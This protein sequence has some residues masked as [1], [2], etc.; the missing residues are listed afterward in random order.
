MASLNAFKKSIDSRLDPTPKRDR[1]FGFV[2]V[3]LM[4]LVQAAF[5][6][7][8]ESVETPAALLKQAKMET[9]PVK[10]TEILDRALEDGR[11]RGRLRHSL[12]YERG[13]AY[14]EMKDCFRAIDSF[15]SSLGHSWKHIPALIEMAHCLIIVDQ[16]D[17]A[18]RIVERVLKT[19]PESGR[20]YVLRGMI[21]EKQGALSRARD[22]YTRALNYD[23]HSTMALELRSKALLKA[24][25]PR[26]A[27]ADIN[28]LARLARHDPDVFVTRARIHLKLK[29][30]ADA[31]ADY[32]TAAKL[33]RDDDRIVKEKAQVFFKMDQPQ[34][35]LEVLSLFT[36]KRGK[37]AAISVLQ[38]RAH[39]LLKNYSKAERM[40]RHV[41]AGDPSHA[42]ALLYRGVALSRRGKFDQALF[43]LNR[44]IELQPR[45]VEAFKERSRTF[46]ELGDP[47]RAAADLSAAAGLD[48]SDGEI[49]ALRGSTFARRMLYDAAIADF[50]RA[51]QCLPGDPRILYDR[52]AAL[53]HK[54]ELASALKD[55]DQILERSRQ[56]ARALS[57]RGMIQ[58]RQGADSKAGMDF[59]QAVKADPTDPLVW[60]NRG[61]FLYKTGKFKHAMQDLN[62]ALDLDPKYEKA[63]Y[64]LSLVLRRRQAP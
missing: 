55:L 5:P 30:Y 15:R 26:A 19:R 40:L 48:P 4:I 34:K 16:I 10:R 64:N 45:L 42:S 21:Y 61:Y 9:D 35:A 20:P 38:A 44:A 2:A 43:Y 57:L 37:D 36:D 47:T 60:N 54:D 14:K 12:Y 51:L 24:G 59:D 7:H 28:S 23:T 25:Q 8:S 62:R 13:M 22:E 29:E 63:R 31:L 3:V 33:A 53:I 17:R 32:K 58:F 39:I 52:A 56:A 46:T 27:L 49:F 41:P 11:A 1:T 6:S 50:S 18:S